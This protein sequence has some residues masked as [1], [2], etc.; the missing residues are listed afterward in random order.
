MNPTS[1]VKVKEEDF[2]EKDLETTAERTGSKILAEIIN[3][4]EI[5]RVHIAEWS[6]NWNAHGNHS[7][8]RG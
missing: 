4:V 1:E 7:N 2:V 8:N 3:R 6:Q 5:E